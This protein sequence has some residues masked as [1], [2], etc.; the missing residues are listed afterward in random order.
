MDYHFP[1]STASSPDVI[2]LGP[3][4]II[5]VGDHNIVDRIISKYKIEW[6]LNSFAPLKS[7]G[8]DNIIPIMLQKS[9]HLIIDIIFDLLVASL[10]LLYIPHV[11]RGVRVVFIPKLGQLIYT[12]ANHFVLSA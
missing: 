9:V 6:A 5:T 1:G 3:N 12:V 2:E 8:E 11:W 10:K 7:P 4:N